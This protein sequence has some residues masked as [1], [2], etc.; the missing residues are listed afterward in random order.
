L[1]GLKKK[2]GNRHSPTL[3]GEKEGKKKEELSESALKGLPSDSR[4]QDERGSVVGGKAGS[5][6]TD[7]NGV[8][9]KVQLG[10]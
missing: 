3:S 5:L 10:R 2:K 4:N 9:K 6:G 1:G 7:G 8:P